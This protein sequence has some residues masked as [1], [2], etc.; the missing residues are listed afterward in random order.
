MTTLKES[1]NKYSALAELLKHRIETGV[2]KPGDRLPSFTEM[3]TE[4]GATPTTVERVHDLLDRQGL[5]H[6]EKRRGVFV[7]EPSAQIPLQTIGLLYT[8]FSDE[9]DLYLVELLRGMQATAREHN[10]EILILNS[11]ESARREKA[12]GVVVYRTPTETLQAGIHQIDKPTTPSWLP[13]GLPCVA[14]LAQVD[15]VATVVYDEYRGIREA[16]GYLRSQ[17]HERIA[18]LV[19]MVSRLRIAGYKDTLWETG[20]AS[21][22]RWIRHVII[23]GP[24]KSY[25]EAG[26]ETMR[27]WFKEDWEEL[28]C[29][30]I[31]AQNDETALG[32]IDAL[33]QAGYSVP[34]QVSVVGFDGLE[35]RGR[36]GDRLTTIEVPL[37]DMGALSVE[38]LMQQ[39]QKTSTQVATVMLP[40]TFR[41]GESTGPAPV[42]KGE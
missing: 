13:G 18:Y 39:I 2:L 15:G 5:I 41:I 33:E 37:R 30:A 16:M 26:Y 29:T 23:A 3:R 31:L 7:S 14:V 25:E 35:G 27:Q 34:G 6:R 36:R 38:L 24:V 22:P 8:A 12:D 40:T 17:G 28:G 4:F 9:L 19:D 11:P 1:T 21:D 10:Y 32:V 20:I 42:S